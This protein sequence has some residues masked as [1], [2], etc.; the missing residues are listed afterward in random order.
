MKGKTKC[1]LFAEF[2]KSGQ[3]IRNSSKAAFHKVYKVYSKRSDFF[4]WRG[5]FVA[6]S[7]YSHAG[8]CCGAQKLHHNEDNEDEDALKKKKQ[9]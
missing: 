6:T 3:I 2:C 9:V 7:D 8:F 1:I 5:W 4:K